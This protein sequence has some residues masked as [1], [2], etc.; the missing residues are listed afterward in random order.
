M[1]GARAKQLRKLAGMIASGKK[2][3]ERKTQ[4]H[5]IV[6]TYTIPGSK[7]KMKMPFEVI[8]LMPCARKF[9]QQFKT[10]YKAGGLRG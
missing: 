2:L 3:P 4:S 1:R 5:R 8:S 6:R 9:Y 10:E 7:K